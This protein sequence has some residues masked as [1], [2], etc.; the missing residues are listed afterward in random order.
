MKIQI[1]T[2]HFTADQKLLSFIEKKINKRPSFKGNERYF[3][4]IFGFSSGFHAQTIR[5][6]QNKN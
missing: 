5:K 1:Q 2:V 3:R 6:T 4:R